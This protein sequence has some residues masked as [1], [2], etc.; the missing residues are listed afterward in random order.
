MVL[1]ATMVHWLISLGP[2]S[3][4]SLVITAARVASIWASYEMKSVYHVA[5]GS[6]VPCLKEIL[7]ESKM[8]K[9]TVRQIHV[10]Q[11]QLVTQ[12]DIYRTKYY[13]W[14]SWCWTI[15]RALWTSML[16]ISIS[17][18]YL[19]KQCFQEAH[20]KYDMQHTKSLSAVL[21]SP[22]TFTI[23]SQMTEC[24]VSIIL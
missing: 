14:M 8:T 4:F 21:V 2:E 15:F 11:L 3:L 16:S 1:V 23:I 6:S 18:A 13:I 19:Y 5:K 10:A 22:L 20:L 7:E 12:A 17:H 24:L 9:L